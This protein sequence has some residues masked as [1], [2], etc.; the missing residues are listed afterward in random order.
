MQKAFRCGLIMPFWAVAFSAVAFSAP[1][2][3]KPFLIT[4]GVIAAIASTMPSIVRRLGRS[5]RR[6]E[7][8]PSVHDAAALVRMDDDGGGHM[9]RR[10]LP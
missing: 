1:Q 8:L 7:V 2:R 5:R 6:A 10:R 4:L 3:E 9:A